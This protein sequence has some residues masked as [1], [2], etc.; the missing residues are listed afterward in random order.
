MLIC[1]Q[2]NTT[3]QLTPSAHVSKCFHWREK[4]LELSSSDT[5]EESRRRN[6]KLHF[7]DTLFYHLRQ[8]QRNVWIR[9][10]TTTTEL[11]SFVTQYMYIWPIKLTLLHPHVMHIHTYVN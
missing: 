3:A 2:G 9:K 10:A 1:T 8:H 6:P 5:L 7:Q 4:V 11:D